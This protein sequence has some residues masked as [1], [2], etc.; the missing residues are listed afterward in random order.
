MSLYDFIL[1]YQ[2]PLSLIKD[3]TIMPEISSRKVRN[4]IKS[5]VPERDIKQE[6]VLLLIDNTLLRSGKQGMLITPRMMYSFSNIS[7]KFSIRLEEIESVSPQVRRVFGNRQ[8]GIVLNEEVFLSLPGMAEDSHIIRDYVEEEAILVGDELSPAIIYFSIF[9][10]KA[11][12]C[13]LLLEKE[14]DPGPPPWYNDN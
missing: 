9:L 14:S 3:I 6:P 10:H 4:A 2:K 5:Y 8:L 7:G 13:K 11:L 1:K 12:N